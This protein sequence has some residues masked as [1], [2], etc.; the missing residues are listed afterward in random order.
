M[1]KDVYGTIRMYV[2]RD[3]KCHEGYGFSDPETEEINPLGL[4]KETFLSSEAR[5]LV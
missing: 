2:G 3:S 1:N 4:A 5:V